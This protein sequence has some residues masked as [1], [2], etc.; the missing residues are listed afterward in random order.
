MRLIDADKLRKPHYAEDD[1]II[2]CWMSPSEQDGYNEAIDEIWQLI[3]NAPTVEEAVIPVRC[4]KC[5]YS[6][7]IDRN[8]SY[9][10]SYIDGC[11]FCI[12][13]D[14]GKLPDDYCSDGVR[15]ETNEP[16]R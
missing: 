6:R 8:D 3:K 13:H 14:K 1:N 16:D 12:E 2:G 11:I 9:E 10:N 7:P 4:E 5:R 15:R